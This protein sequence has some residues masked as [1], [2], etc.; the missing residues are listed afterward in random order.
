VSGTR[1]RGT[2]KTILIRH[3]RDQALKRLRDTSVHVTIEDSES[4]THVFEHAMATVRRVASI[5]LP[6]DFHEVAGWVTRND[7]K[8]IGEIIRET[9]QHIALQR[10]VDMMVHLG[11]VDRLRQLA[12][13]GLRIRV[14]SVFTVP[15]ATV[16]VTFGRSF[17]K[18]DQSAMS[19]ESDGDFLVRLQEMAITQKHMDGDIGFVDYVM[20]TLT[21]AEQEQLRAIAAAEGLRTDVLLKEL[22]VKT[23]AARAD[24]DQTI[25]LAN[26]LR[27]GKHKGKI[28]SEHATASGTTKVEISTGRAGCTSALFAVL[29]V[30]CVTIGALCR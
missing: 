29:A 22:H 5:E 9:E 6:T 11:M 14:T 18:G 23:V 27:D 13:S 12:A 20:R 3:L 24:I 30:M 2:E 4:V 28:S 26:D 25:K 10:V 15:T 8:A 21:P 16:H 17:W 7:A 1:L 19:T